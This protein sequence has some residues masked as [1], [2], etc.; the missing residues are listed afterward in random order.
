MPNNILGM[1]KSLLNSRWT[2][3]W[4]GKYA[5]VRVSQE[6]NGRIVYDYEDMRC[7]EDME[8]CI[9]DYAAFVTK[10]K[11]VGG[12]TDSNAVIERLKSYATDSSYAS[13]LRSL[14]SKYNLN[15][16]N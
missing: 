5:S 4:L 8:A 12:M 9:E 6:V 16:Y 3:P 2:S 11:G 1:N 14:I 10:V 7:Y 15:Q 13:K